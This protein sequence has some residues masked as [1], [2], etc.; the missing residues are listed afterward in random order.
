MTN[1][2]FVAA[3]GQAGVFQSPSPF[4]NQ[5]I[6]AFT[7]TSS[8]VLPINGGCLISQG[9]GSSNFAAAMPE[10]QSYLLMLAGVAAMAFVARRRRN[11]ES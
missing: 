6:A 8:Q 10:P 2:S 4:C 7:K 9:G 1:L 5:A 11:S 3:V